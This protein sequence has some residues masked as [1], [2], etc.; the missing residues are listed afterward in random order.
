MAPEV[1]LERV[2]GGATIMSFPLQPTKRDQTAGEMM[3]L[4]PLRARLTADEPPLILTDADHVFAVDAPS[5]EAAD[6]RGWQCQAMGGVVLG[7]VSDDQD[8]ESP[9]QP[10][11]GGPIRMTPIRPEGLAIEAAVL[12][13]PT[14][15]VPAIIPKA[16]QQGFRGIPG[17][18]ADIR[19][20]TAPAMAGI[21][22][23]LEC[24][25]LCGGAPLVP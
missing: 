13:E 22:E 10:A 8:L 15:E 14:D 7:A 2:D 4:R 17:V 20:V 16:L 18:N 23:E 12:L 24:Q 9:A 21:A 19:W 11:S 6:L 5:R 25:H 1:A 3:E